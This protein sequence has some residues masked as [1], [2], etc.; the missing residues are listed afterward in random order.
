[1]LFI[2]CCRPSAKRR[3][4]SVPLRV[5]EPVVESILQCVVGSNNADA[6]NVG[7]SRC[8]GGG[9]GDCFVVNDDND[10]DDDA[11]D[12]DDDD[13]IDVDEIIVELLI[14]SCSVVRRRCCGR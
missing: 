3:A 4:A 13:D 1:M 9:G 11:E 14:A 2:S 6:C 8:R 5:V 10:D 7:N 12:G